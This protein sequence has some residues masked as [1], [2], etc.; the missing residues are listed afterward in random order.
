MKSLPRSAAAVAKL[1]LSFL[2]VP[3]TPEEKCRS[4][5]EL[6]PESEKGENLDGKIG[7]LTQVQNEWEA[8]P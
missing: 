2:T 4:F 5:I 7:Q 1:S 6:P 8:T 3:L